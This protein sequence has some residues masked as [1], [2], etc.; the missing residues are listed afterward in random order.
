[1]PTH[2]PGVQF[3]VQTQLSVVNDSIA[4]QLCQGQLEVTHSLLEPVSSRG[5]SVTTREELSL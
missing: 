5:L 2:L 4:S 1:M 3:E